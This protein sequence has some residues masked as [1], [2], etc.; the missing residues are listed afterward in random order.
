MYS[1]VIDKLNLF[2]SCSILVYG[3]II[4]DRFIYGDVNRISP[5]APV[6]ILE[7]QK[8]FDYLGGSGNVVRNL[9]DL[10]V[11]VTCCSVVGND[12]AADQLKSLFKDEDK[13][14]LDGLFVDNSRKTTIKTRIISD[15]KH[16]FRLDEED[17]HHVSSQLQKNIIQFL[18]RIIPTVDCIIISDYNKGMIVEDCI[19]SLISLSLK[20]DKPVFVDPK[21]DNV[22]LYKRVKCIKPNFSEVKNLISSRGYENIS[23]VEQLGKV[24]LERLDVTYVLITQGEL[25]MSLIYKDGVYH[26]TADAK[27]IFDVTGAG[28]T[29]IAMISLCLVVGI[30]I[31][32]SMDIANFAAR[33]VIGKVGTSTITKKELLENI[34]N[35]IK[36]HQAKHI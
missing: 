1:N 4:L 13:I 19:K 17:R 32:L 2:S 21:L 18:S 36:N 5:E 28:D 22:S 10:D 7:I 14:N 33:I 16:M 34:E 29:V 3:D 25:G 9:L 26:A 20:C 35:I 15:S 6:P 11:N 23:R 27:K 8:R 12:V 30:D 24:F 31:K